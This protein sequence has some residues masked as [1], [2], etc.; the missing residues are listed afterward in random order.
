VGVSWDPELVD[1]I[2][3]LHLIARELVWGMSTGL[4]QS[5]KSTRSIEFLEH[6]EYTPGESI[7]DIDWKV[8]ARND[9]LMI[10][11]QQADTEVNI[12]IVLDA[13]GDMA[14]TST[15]FPSLENSK[16]GKALS[17]AAALTLYAV[18]SAEPVGLILSGG[19]G[20][21]HDCIPP[22]RRSKA[23]IFDLLARVKPGGKADLHN[24]LPR[25][26]PLLTQKSIVVL[27]SDW[28]EEPAQWG[29]SLEMLS[30]AGHDIRVLHLYSKGEWSLDLPDS[31]KLF[32]YESPQEINLDIEKIKSEF[33][34]IVSNYQQEV[35]DWAL[36]SRAIWS[37]A[38]LEES[39]VLPLIT[40]VKGF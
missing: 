31:V 9:K 23:A 1:R 4:H 7:R 36:R 19:T 15:G 2:S 38:A 11:K 6:K 25:L 22:S 12:F 13:S 21:N 10:R 20:I 5:S 30:A 17:L 34:L 3:S 18:R 39:L 26:M 28:M 40:V 35:E 27:I 33:K 16:M 24:N 37:M 29:P 14:T 32:S 8:F